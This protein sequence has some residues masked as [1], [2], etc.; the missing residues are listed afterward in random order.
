M[1]PT[2]NSY[3]AALAAC[4]WIDCHPP[5]TAFV[6]TTAPSG[7]QVKAILWRYVNRIHAASGLVGRMNQ[8][9][10]WI[11][12]EMV[13][14]GRKPSDYSP[15]TFQGIHAQFVLAILDEA[16]G[17]EEQLWNAISTIT[18]NA[19][20]RTL[21]IGNPDDPTSY[22][23]KVC[24]PGST[25]NVQTISAFDS[26]NLTGEEVPLEMAASLI[27]AEWVARKKIEWGEDSPLYQSKITGQ[28]P[29]DAEDGIIPASFINPCRYLGESTLPD[30]PSAGGIDVGDTNDRTVIFERR[31]QRA[32]RFK[33]IDHSG[34]AMNAVG[35]LVQ[36]INEWQLAFVTVDV[37]GVG[38]GVYSR[39][40]ELSR[41]DNPTDPLTSHSAHVQRFSA[42]E[43]AH[44]PVRFV[45]KR[46]ELWWDIGREL[47]REH[48]WDL[49]A[50]DDDVIAELTTPKYR[51]EGSKGRILVE[52]KE[53]IRKRIGRSTDLADSLLMA[54]YAGEPPIPPA[55][56]PSANRRAAETSLTGS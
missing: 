32:G 50:V 16:C 28:F 19:G 56:F 39:L 25:W 2:H 42:G 10:M 7:A 12:N 37:I 11:G 45:N 3:V 30:A 38:W 13:A 29:K 33:V 46:A 4:W 1:A 54:F 47:S 35:L 5:G 53:D 41:I 24:Q 8:T 14:L 36:V 9:E 55:H 51:L 34:D 26:P 49:S 18:S 17:I 52:S 48:G 31:G 6:L 44:D 43:Q 40:R 15:D 22:F 23:A 20:A 27:S 21:A